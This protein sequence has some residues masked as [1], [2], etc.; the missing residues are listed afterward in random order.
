MFRKNSQEDITD[1]EFD[2]IVCPFDDEMR[3]YVKN[4]ILN[5]YVAFYI[6]EGYRKSAIWECSMD[7]MVA[8]AIEMLCQY[9]YKDC[10]YNKIKELLKVEYDLEVINEK[11]V[12][13]K[14]LRT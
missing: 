9:T 1:E 5:Q 13:V 3:D 10:Y 4:N 6:A 2:N 8:T 11:P 7:A 12:Q 14:D